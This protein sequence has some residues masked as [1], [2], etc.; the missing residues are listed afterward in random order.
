MPYNTGLEI[1]QIRPL[2][3]L[4]CWTP[5]PSVV[6]L[7]FC[8]INICADRSIFIHIRWNHLYKVKVLVGI[9]FHDLE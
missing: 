9:C 7:Y 3:I 8:N 6:P 5:S 2:S 1:C 4:F